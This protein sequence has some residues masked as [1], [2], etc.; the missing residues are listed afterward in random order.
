MSSMRTRSSARRCFR[1]RLRS[2]AYISRNFG[3]CFS[4]IPVSMRTFF[5]PVLISRQVRESRMRFLSSAG[6][7]FSQTGL[8]T[9]PNMAPPSSLNVPSLTACSSKSPSLCMLAPAFRSRTA[10]LHG[11]LPALQ[12]REGESDGDDLGDREKHQAQ[13]D[14]AREPVGMQAH[15]ELVDPEPGPAHHD[16]SEDG[17]DR[18][19]PGPRQSPPASMQEQRVPQHD[20]QGPV[21]L[22]VPA[23][24]AA[25]GII[26]PEP[27]EDRSDEA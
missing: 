10:E 7:T 23:P 20:H 9:M 26:G 15:A 18:D 1:F 6:M 2:T 5:F 4:P 11:A 24:E 14:A 17:Q 16:V 25:P 27:A 8:G 19:A 12:R 22:G 3:S 21:L 13:G